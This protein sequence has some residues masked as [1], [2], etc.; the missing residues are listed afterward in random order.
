MFILS[1][2]QLNVCI[3]ILSHVAVWYRNSRSSFLLTNVRCLHLSRECQLFG[4]CSL[5]RLQTVWCIQT[6]AIPSWW[7]EDCPSREPVAG[8][9]RKGCPAP[10]CCECSVFQKITGTQQCVLKRGLKSRWTGASCGSVMWAHNIVPEWTLRNIS[11]KLFPFLSWI[12]SSHINML[13]G[14]AR[15]LFWH[16]VGRR[17]KKPLWALTC[18][19]GFPKFPGARSSKRDIYIGHTFEYILFFLSAVFSNFGCCS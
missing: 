9:W 3:L 2:M 10:H 12:F 6:G 14:S 16:V 8:L 19:A 18:Q 4:I 7:A 5:A 15:P 17:R 1:G 11:G 13:G